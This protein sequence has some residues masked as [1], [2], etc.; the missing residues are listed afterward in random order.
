MS[1]EL[2]FF[3]KADLSKYRG[4]YVAIIGDKIIAAGENAEEVW[5]E[6]KRKYPDKTPKIAKIPSEE[7]LI[8]FVWK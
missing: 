2:E 4:K 3:L 1:R 6:S 8:L 7:V 5:K